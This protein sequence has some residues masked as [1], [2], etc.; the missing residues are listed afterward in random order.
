[1]S[2]RVMPCKGGMLAEGSC[3]DSQS[4]GSGNFVI[5]DWLSRL[6]NGRGRYPPV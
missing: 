6:G 5:V 2:S 4:R 1:M 3:A